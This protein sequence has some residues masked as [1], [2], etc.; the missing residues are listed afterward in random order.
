MQKAFEKII[1][2]VKEYYDAVNP[3]VGN[4]VTKIVNQV[5]EEYKSTEHINCSTDDLISRSA[6]LGAMDKR[7]KEKE[8]NVLDNLAEG[9]VQM[10]KLIKEQPIVQANDGWI[11][12]SERL[13]EEKGTYLVTI[14]HFGIT[15][16]RFSGMKDN[17]HFDSNVI[18]W[19]PLPQPYV[20]GE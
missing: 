3:Y 6:L 1:E 7:Y 12:C 17:L 4:T 19:Q 10:E 2:K 5:A 9:F 8:G 13:P 18:A 14:K 11:P 20:K 16:A 15:F